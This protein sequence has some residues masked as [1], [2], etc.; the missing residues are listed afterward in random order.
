[1]LLLS[2]GF[3][4]GTFCWKDGIFTSGTTITVPE[5]CVGSRL[6][7]SPSS[8]MMDAYSVPCAPET[9]AS[10]GPGLLPRT[11]TTGICVAAS[12]PAGTSIV[13]VTFCPAS[14]VALP[15]EKEDCCPH[16]ETVINPQ[17]ARKRTRIARTIGPPAHE[18]TLAPPVE[19]ML[20][21]LRLAYA[22]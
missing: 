21:Y 8:A 4:C 9:S 15:T 7:I 6:P 2:T 10:V 5:T 22:C 16:A 12:D 1:M 20:S 11:T 19:Q 17:A 13:P 14:A 3:T 18:N